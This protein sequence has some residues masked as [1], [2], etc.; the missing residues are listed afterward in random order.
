M[1]G[2]AQQTISVRDFAGKAVLV[3][4]G[5]ILAAGPVHDILT[6]ALVT[7]CFDYPIEIAH[8]EGR[9]SA[10]GAGA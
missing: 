7:E 4:G 10:R 6:T 3:T 2:A 9:W 1:N 8:Q 5:R